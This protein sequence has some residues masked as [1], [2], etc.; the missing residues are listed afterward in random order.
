VLW[1]AVWL[2]AGLTWAESAR[3]L[4]AE[5]NKHYRSEEIDKAKEYYD[6]ALEIDPEEAAAVY[7]K[8]N[9]LYRQG[10]YGAAID[11]YKQA[12]AKTRDRQLAARAK[13]N[14]G[15]SY[16]KQAEGLEKTEEKIEAF[17]NGI[18]CWRQVQKMQP[19][20]AS[21]AKNIEAARLKIQEAKKQQEQQQQN[22]PQDQNQPSDPN[23]P[24]EI[25]NQ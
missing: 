12:A 18:D 8:A 20:H 13:Y 6:K 16:Y 4:V 2:T 19:D 15:N 17:E 1:L 22:Q 11:A 14:L 7:N 21:A 25:S 23:Q 3:G 24:S 9:S 10:D 5:G